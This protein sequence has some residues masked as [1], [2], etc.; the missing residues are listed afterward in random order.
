MP[1]SSVEL[2]LPDPT[3]HPVGKEHSGLAAQQQLRLLRHCGLQP[4]SNLMEI[5]CGIGRLVHELAPYLDGGT[6]AGFDISPAAIEWLNENYAPL[7][8]GYRF[9]LVEVHN[10]RYRPRA[11][12][13]PERARFPY[14]DDQF[15]FSCSFSVFTHMQASEIRHYLNELRRV[16]VPGGRG[17]MTFFAVNPDDVDPHLDAKRP[18]LPIGEGAYAV[19][20]E[21]PERAIAFDDALIRSMVA[22]AGLEVADLVPGRWRIK[23]RW[24]RSPE[25]HH[26][27]AYVLTPA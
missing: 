10:A 19:D 20:P 18:F 14:D 12:D 23:N 13:S 22:D 17:V 4:T 8:P 26:K 27:D 3:I 6:Y 5:G 11:D 7:L 1:T 25:M 9:D 15:D 16:L 2:P 24:E 21:L